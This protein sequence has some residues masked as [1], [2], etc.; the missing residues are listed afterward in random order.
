MSA[1]QTTQIVQQIP[2]TSVVAGNNDRKSFKAEPL[3]ELAA[4][5]AQHGLA[6]PI[7]LRPFEDGTYQIVAGERRFR[8][9]ADILK[10]D[11]VPAIVRVLSDEEAAAIMLVE[12]TSRVDLDPI[13]EAEAYRV[14]QE[15]FSWSISHIA[16]IAGVNAERVRTRLKLLELPSDIR[17]HVQY[18]HFPIGHAQLLVDAGL[19][20]N[21]QRIAMRVFNSA[22]SM[23][24]SRFQDMVVR[25]LTEEQA[26]ECI[27]KYEA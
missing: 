26:Q 18:G 1:I 7:T 22:S 11:T 12:N 2:V 25:R 13:A 3:K 8:A 5:I 6:Q 23:P 16:D 24:L 9:I 15:R 21:R 14:R 4:S 17:H 27:D 10:W 20:V 19:D